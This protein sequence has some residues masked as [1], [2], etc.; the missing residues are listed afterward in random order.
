MKFK[1]C[2]LTTL[3]I[4]AIIISA[5]PLSAYAACSHQ[6]GP[7]YSEAAHPHQYFRQCNL[8]AYKQYTGGNATKAH[9]DGSWGSGTC[10]S[11]G[12]HY[13]VG[14]SCNS[15]GICDCGS[16]ISPMGHTY[17]TYCDA[18]H[19]HR[20]FKQ[21]SSCHN[22]YYLNT[23][24][25][26]NHGSGATGSGTCPSCGSH[27]Y[28]PDFDALAV[29]PHPSRNVCVCGDM[30]IIANS[31]LLASCPTCAVN[32]K[33]VKTTVDQSMGFSYIDEGLVTIFVDIYVEY[34]ETYKKDGTKF[35]HFSSQHKGWYIPV[36][37]HPDIWI[38]PK[39]QMEYRNSS[40][41]KIH[42]GTIGNTVFTI[43]SLP[44][45][46]RTGVTGMVA[47]SGMLRTLYYDTYYSY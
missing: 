33:Y 19:P 26:K 22:K 8:C 47:G 43:N 44:S 5:I 42:T 17:I 29:H 16:Y 15:P 39:N 36:A 28:F 20:D 23:Y 14:R 3:L 2:L 40:D 31:N 13:Y 6:W 45:Y 4:C 27:R 38:T 12:S 30:K 9:G 34:S 7:Q 1:K 10:P 37:S 11:C 24:T 35:I 25:T 32:S 21:C 41:S 46:S 18:A